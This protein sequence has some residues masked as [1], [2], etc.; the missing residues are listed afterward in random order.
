MIGHD[1]SSFFDTVD[2]SAESLRIDSPSSS[3]RCEPLIEEKIEET[4]AYYSFP[5]NHWVRIRT[6]NALERIMHEIRH[7]TRV[8]GAFPE[9]NSALMPVAARLRHISG[10]Q[11]GAKRYLSM[12]ELYRLDITEQQSA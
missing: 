12:D 10:T 3:R 1:K 7:R 9:G 6:N 5:D 11:W 4:F 2:F 8:V